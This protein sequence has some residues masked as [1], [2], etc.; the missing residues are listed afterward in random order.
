MA[1][2]CGGQNGKDSGEN[3]PIYH[4]LDPVIVAGEPPLSSFHDYQSIV[5]VQRELV[6]IRSSGSANS[7]DAAAV[8]VAV[9]ACTSV[10]SSHSCGDVTGHVSTTPTSGSSKWTLFSRLRLPRRTTT[11]T[12]HQHQH[13]QG[14]VIS[15]SDRVVTSPPNSAPAISGSRCAQPSCSPTSWRG[16]HIM[17]VTRADY[18]YLSTADV[19][20][21]L[22]AV[23]GGNSPREVTVTRRDSA[24]QRDSDVKKR[25]RRRLVNSSPF[26]SPCCG[27]RM[28]E[29]RAAWRIQSCGPRI[30]SDA[31]PT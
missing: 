26:S 25:G 4:E 31:V 9:A 2:D 6:H 21:H 29:I 1:A 30:I 12:I 23:P 15:T 3:S 14:H 5:D 24:E 8:T 13:Q 11:A 19:R 20:R 17:G 7:F 16:E 28:A 22:A 18:F 27:V 10:T